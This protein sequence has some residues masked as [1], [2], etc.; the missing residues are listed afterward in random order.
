MK[1]EHKS[2]GASTFLILGLTGIAAAVGGYLASGVLQGSRSENE[3]AMPSAEGSRLTPRAATH[4]PAMAALVRHEPSAETLELL[5]RGRE[6]GF[7]GVVAQLLHDD[8]T[9]DV[10]DFIASLGPDDLPDF[11]RAAMAH[12]GGASEAMIFGLEH[13]IE[14]DHE[15]FVEFAS[16][17]DDLEAFHWLGFCTHLSGP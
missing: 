11:Y 3:S 5:A 12:P 16:S 1:A 17:S 6:E 9:L 13:W 15:G 2:L 7:E 4:S 14:I 10:F 8:S